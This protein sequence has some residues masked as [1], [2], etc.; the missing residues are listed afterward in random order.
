MREYIDLLYEDK[1]N[2]K[3]IEDVEFEFNI[4]KLDDYITLLNMR[5]GY[6]PM[7]LR[8]F[9]APD[10]IENQ[11]PEVRE[12]FNKAYHITIIATQPLLDEFLNKDLLGWLNDHLEFNDIIIRKQ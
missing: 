7:L 8:R 3:M 5:E 2:L 4:E 6:V 1:D 9:L 11:T 12:Q 10:Y